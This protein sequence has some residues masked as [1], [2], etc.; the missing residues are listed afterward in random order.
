MDQ[1]GTYEAIVYYTCPV[2][3][4]GST[5]ELSFKDSRLTGKITEAHDPPLVGA[6]QDRA[7]RSESLVKDFQPL[8]LG[9]I[10]LPKG[11]GELTLRALEI[12]GKQ[13][14]DFRLLIL[15]RID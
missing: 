7:Q 6:E 11:T 2:A 3:D 14:M 4:V 1:A 15:N 5:V 12:P 9:N 13:V 8:V 10:Q